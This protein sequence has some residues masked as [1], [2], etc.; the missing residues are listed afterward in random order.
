MSPL[1]GNGSCPH[2]E[3]M[4]MGTLHLQLSFFF[5]RPRVSSDVSR[6]GPST[7]GYESSAIPMGLPFL[8]TLVSSGVSLL[9]CPRVS[10]ISHWGLAR[11]MN[12]QLQ[13]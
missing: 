13:H 1:D 3:E 11:N 12:Y 7:S 6:L 4:A 9:A 10:L 5:K 8:C 2:C